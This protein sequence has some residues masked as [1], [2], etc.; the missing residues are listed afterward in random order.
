MSNNFIF[1]W[2]LVGNQRVIDF[3]ARSLINRRLA[4][5]YLF[6]GP[7]NLGKTTIAA[8]FVQIILCNQYTAN[9]GGDVPCGVCPSCQ[10]FQFL[11]RKTSASDEQTAEDS[12]PATLHS[13]YYII[14]SPRDK[15]NISIVQIRELIKNLGM[16]PFLSSY[17]VGIIKRAEYLSESAAN[18]LLKTLEE[19][20]VNSII[21][22]VANQLEFLPPTIRSRCQIVEFKPVDSEAIYQYLTQEKGVARAEAKNLAYLSLGRP[23]LA[24][25]FLENADFAAKYKLWAEIFLAIIKSDDYNFRL[26][27]LDDLTQREALDNAA[28]ARRRAKRIIEVWEG[29]SR[30]LFLTQMGHFPLVQHQFFLPEF[31]KLKNKFALSKI[32]N[33]LAL[34]KEGRAYLQA[35]LSPKLVLEN[36]VISI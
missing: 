4:N 2:P 23:A 21:I 7:D 25:K 19:P 10:K 17:K 32:L 3:L 5:A 30:D 11:S 35:N 1:H 31:K 13:D 34:L 29:V 14:K 27:R 28:L 12:A 9:R 20:P 33:V 24:V 22:L 16:S 6:V 18:T 8:R 26:S 15:N 36:I